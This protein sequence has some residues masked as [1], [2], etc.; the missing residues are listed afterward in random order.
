MSSELTRS[1]GSPLFQWAGVLAYW[2][3]HIMALRSEKWYH[4]PINV[5]GAVFWAWFV[6][7][8]IRYYYVGY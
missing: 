1:E 6:W 8:C 5:L 4:E 2:K 7:R 3:G